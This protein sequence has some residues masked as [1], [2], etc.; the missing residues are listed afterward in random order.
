M[1]PLI[2]S[3]KETYKLINKNVLEVYK[4]GATVVVT[5][6]VDLGI[7]TMKNKRIFNQVPGMEVLPIII[8]FPE[9]INEIICTIYVK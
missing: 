3:S 7:K 1:L 9:L 8:N 5:A 4:D 6:N 2:S